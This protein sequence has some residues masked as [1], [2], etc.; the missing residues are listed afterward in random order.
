M[1]KSFP[2]SLLRSGM[3]LAFL[4]A[5][6]TGCSVTSDFVVVEDQTLPGLPLP[7]PLVGVPLVPGLSCNL[8]DEAALDQA[9]EDAIG[10]F[11][12]GIFTVKE[13]TL[14]SLEVSVNEGSPGDFSAISR[15]TLTLLVLDTDGLRL[16]QIPLGSAENPEGFGRL[17]QLPLDTPADLLGILRSGGDCGALALVADGKYPG[18]DV[19]FDVRA[20]VRIR[21]GL[22]R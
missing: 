13:A 1:R 5:L 12:A 17:V 7:L 20:R 14:L 6:M 11:L 9:V 8:P 16:D 10:P 22:R 19:T 4:G 18:Q 21:P 2:A 15:L 3:V